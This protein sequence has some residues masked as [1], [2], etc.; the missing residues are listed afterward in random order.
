[1]GLSRYVI[2]FD[3]ARA[4]REVTIDVTLDL[5]QASAS[6]VQNVP[7]MFGGAH[8]SNSGAKVL[9][10]LLGHQAPDGCGCGWFIQGSPN[11]V[12]AKASA[13]GDEDSVSDTRA[14]VTMTATN[15]YGDNLLPAGHYDLL[16]RGYALAD[17]VGAGDWGT[18]SSTMSGRIEDIKV[19]TPAE[20]STLTLTA[21]KTKSGR[22]LTATLT[23][24]GSAPINGR[25]I[26]F[27]GDG[28]FLGTGVTQNGVATF[29]AGGRF[30]GGAHVFR[31]EFAGDDTYSSSA[32]QTSS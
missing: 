10:Q 2:G 27:Y 5:D 13:V 19:T 12:V 3:L 23:D 4:T 18:L 22:L 1:M 30:R 28:E 25:T 26:S 16:L 8:N 31:A 7:E 20:A 15:P 14:H 9:F 17:L 32:A 21:A 6:W 24:A 11:V 29:L